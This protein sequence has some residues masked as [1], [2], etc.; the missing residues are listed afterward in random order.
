MPMPKNVTVRD[1][2]YCEE[3]ENAPLEEQI[4]GASR[5]SRIPLEL[6]IHTTEK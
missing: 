3:L 4:H 5:G 2:I 6:P 1:M